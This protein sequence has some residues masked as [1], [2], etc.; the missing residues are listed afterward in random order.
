MTFKEWL[1]KF[2]DRINDS[3]T[4]KPL[5]SD[6]ASFQTAKLVFEETKIKVVPTLT[7][8]LFFGIFLIAGIGVIFLGVA[9]EEQTTLIATCI[10]GSVFAL[11]GLGGIVIPRFLLRPEFDLLDKS[12][13]PK[14]KK[15]YL[16]ALNS[17]ERLKIPLKEF[18]FLRILEKTCS[19][20]KGGSYSCYELNIVI[21]DDERYNLLNHGNFLKLYADAEKLAKILKLPLVDVDNQKYVFN[22]EEYFKET[23]KGNIVLLLFGLVFFAFGGTMYYFAVLRTLGSYFDS[24][25][26]VDVPAVVVEST[27]KRVEQ[28]SYSLNIVY[29]YSF[30]N[31]SYKSDAYDFFRKGGHSSNIGT[32]DMRRIQKAYPVGKKFSAL[33]NPDN[34]EEAVAVR[35]IGTNGWFVILLGGIF[36]VIGFVII[37]LAVKSSVKTRRK[38]RVMKFN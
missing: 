6:S 3:D 22:Q 25:S 19:G 29:S 7:N 4:V 8:S 35:I 34:P 17:P 16:A 23:R 30:N 33:V 21:S 28:D 38:N 10:F 26:W 31:Q 20:S 13:Y 11:V 9:N 15:K 27:L 18:K 5:R 32:A 1:I 24:A 2:K 14:S 36:P 37:F 12:F